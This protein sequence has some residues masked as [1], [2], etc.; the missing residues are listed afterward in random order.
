MIC[1]SSNHADIVA[2]KFLT[3]V[4]LQ[5]RQLHGAELIEYLAK[6]RSEV[7]RPP[8]TPR[9]TR[10]GKRPVRAKG[11]PGGEG[12][13]ARIIEVTIKEHLAISEMRSKQ[14]MALW[15]YVQRGQRRLQLAKGQVFG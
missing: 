4:R 9:P 1:F 5:S 14:V 10:A 2:T 15:D 6:L 12:R 7:R 11:G 8:P 13:Q 3:P